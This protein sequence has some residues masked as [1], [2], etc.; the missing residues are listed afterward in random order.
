MLSML[1]FSNL[2]LLKSY[3][4]RKATAS[5]LYI[6]KKLYQKVNW[7]YLKNNN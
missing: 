5:I 4:T 1:R 7:P 2:T 3:E 6:V